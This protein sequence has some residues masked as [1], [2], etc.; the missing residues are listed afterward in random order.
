MDDV[1]RGLDFCF[2][3]L[4]DILIFSRSL[5]EH[6]Q[7]IWALFDQLQNYGILINP[8]KCIFRAHEITL[9]GYKVSAKGSQP[10]EERVTHLQECQPPKTANQLRR[11]LGMLNYYRRFLPHAASDQAPL[12]DVLSR[13]KIKGSHPITWTLELHEAFEKCKANF[14]TRHATGTP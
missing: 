14:F 3:Y 7:H 4:D 10:L 9:L 2:A 6:E 5:A 1:L 13:P 12:H 11:F 8:G